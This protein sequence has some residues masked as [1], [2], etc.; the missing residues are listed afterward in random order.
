MNKVFEKYIDKRVLCKSEELAKDFLQLAHD[1]GWKW[2]TEE[3]LLGSTYWETYKNFTYYDVW[4]NKKITY[5]STER[6]RINEFI[7]YE[8]L[9]KDK[10]A[11]QEETKRENK[12]TKK[13]II[14]EY[15]TCDGSI[16]YA[17]QH[18]LDNNPNYKL[19]N[20]QMCF[21]DERVGMYALVSYELR[22]KENERHNI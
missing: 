1:N 10:D 6:Y 22:S 4:K 18:F 7:E 13:Q 16:E 9:C 14:K 20:Y 17:I 11:S 5:G 15:W 21:C 3:S 12:M 19:T 8:P 2:V